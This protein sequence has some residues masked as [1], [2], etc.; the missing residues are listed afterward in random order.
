MDDERRRAAKH[1]HS[2]LV[3]LNFGLVELRAC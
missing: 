2:D 3:E 1:G